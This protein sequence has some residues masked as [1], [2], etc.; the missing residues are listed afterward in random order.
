[1]DGMDAGSRTPVRITAC[2]APA[3]GIKAFSM[4]YWTA[5]F[6]DVHQST[7][8]TRVT[9]SSNVSAVNEIG[10]FLHSSGSARQLGSEEIHIPR[11]VSDWSGS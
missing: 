2:H 5:W 9:V 10:L 8:V 6:Q 3:D 11:G 4:R 1:M 7:S